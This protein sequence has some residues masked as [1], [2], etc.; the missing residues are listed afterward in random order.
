MCSQSWQDVKSTGL[1]S[2]KVIEIRVMRLLPHAAQVTPSRCLGS[3]RI[4]NAEL[5]LGRVTGRRT[6]T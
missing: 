4:P 3:G 6:G 5:G 2:V 1:P